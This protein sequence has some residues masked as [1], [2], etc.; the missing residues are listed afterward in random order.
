MILKIMAI[1]SIG[2]IM[3]IKLTCEDAISKRN[4]KYR[5]YNFELI[6]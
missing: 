6:Q 3:H 1:F 5:I 4:T 2:K